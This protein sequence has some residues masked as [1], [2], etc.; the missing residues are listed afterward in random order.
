[1]SRLKL[2]FFW[3]WLKAEFRWRVLGKRYAVSLTEEAQRQLDEL[4]EEDQ[5]GIR[6]V[7]DRLSRNPYTSDRLAEMEEEE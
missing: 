3:N 2:R 1:V 7:L 4:P 5:A 6:K